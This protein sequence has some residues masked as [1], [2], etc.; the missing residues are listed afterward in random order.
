MTQRKRAIILGGS[1]AGLVAARVL[2]EHFEEVMLLERDPFLFSTA[3]RK[4][5]PQGKHAHA[6]L[7]TGVNILEKFFPGFLQELTEAGAVETKMGRD[8]HW[9]HDGLWKSDQGDTISAPSLTRPLLEQKLGL[10][11][12]NIKNVTLCGEHEVLGFISNPEKT[13]ICGV[14][15]RNK[16]GE[17][18][19]LADLI[20]DASGRGSQTPARLE[21]LGYARPA[22]EDVVVDVGY[23]TRIYQRID[24]G[25]YKGIMTTPKAPDTKLGLILCIE[26]DRTIV[27]LGGWHKDYPPNDE[28][29][30]LDFAKKLAVP[31]IYNFLKSAT[32]LTEISIHRFPSSSR[33][34]YEDLTR[35]PKGLLVMGDAVC[36]FN[37]VYA[38]G[39]TVSS[40]EA[41][42]LDQSLR[43]SG[44]IEQ[45]FQKEIAKIVNVPW[46]LVTTEDFRYPQT[47]G[48]KPFGLSFLQWYVG[49]VHER[50]GDDVV[51]QAFYQVMNM[52]KPPQSL[53]HPKILRRVLGKK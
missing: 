24:L 42:A 50:A 16:D 49:R 22:Q 36:S 18:E 3:T 44:E 45:R 52:L 2:S 33:R 40:L 9:Y 11:V 28:A 26:G 30:F 35:W 51:A 10:R 25:K 8:F 53:F 27:T 43:S 13:Q 17:R 1:F 41:V 7:A 12:S 31:D 38:Q 5:V 15:I 19:Q 34:R 47:Q 6:I 48:K 21:E 14:R 29:G 23:A 20:V 46:T 39:M 4:G 32:P 37:P